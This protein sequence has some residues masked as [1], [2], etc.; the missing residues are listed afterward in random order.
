MA[1]LVT[2]RPSCCMAGRSALPIA[3][4]QGLTLLHFSAQ[5]KRF[6]WDW[7]CIL[8]LLRGYCGGFQGC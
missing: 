8:V 2:G 3:S 7:G 6:V 4:V 1:S 5:G